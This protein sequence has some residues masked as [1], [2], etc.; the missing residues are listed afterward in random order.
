[1]IVAKVSAEGSHLK[2]CLVLVYPLGLQSPENLTSPGYVH[3]QSGSLTCPTCKYWLL[4]GGLSSLPGVS[5]HWL[6]I[7]QS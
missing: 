1:M 7:L 4:V 2:A 6:S 5:R 3:F